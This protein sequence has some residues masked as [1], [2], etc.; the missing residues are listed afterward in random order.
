LAK[1]RAER[2]QIFTNKTFA[3][4]AADGASDEEK[5]LKKKQLQIAL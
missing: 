3:A 2:E 5:R 4:Y 1:V